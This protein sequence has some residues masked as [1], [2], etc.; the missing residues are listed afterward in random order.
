M[1]FSPDSKYFLPPRSNYSLQDPLRKH[2]GITVISLRQH[3]KLLSHIEEQVVSYIWKQH[4]TTQ[5]QQN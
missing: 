4:C 5:G 1:K 3:T 2:Q